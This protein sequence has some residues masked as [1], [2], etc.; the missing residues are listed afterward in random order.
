MNYTHFS[1]KLVR[2]A[3]SL[4]HI[5]AHTKEDT[6]GDFANIKLV[7][8]EGFTKYDLENIT[9]SSAYHEA[10]FDALLTG[11]CFLKM[12]YK[13][14]EQ[15]KK[16]VHSTVNILKNLHCLKIYEELDPFNRNGVSL[17]LVL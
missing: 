1:S 2:G 3:S 14:D 8:P 7:Y 9:E 4:E 6:N 15:E 16:K 13:L 5:W 11:Y 10:G 12:F 17:P